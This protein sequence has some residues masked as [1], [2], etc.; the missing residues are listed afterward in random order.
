MHPTVLI[1]LSL[2][3]ASCG[4]A[5]DPAE[6]VISRLVYGNGDA[7][8]MLSD[9]SVAQERCAGGA[10]VA[11]YYCALLDLADAE[12]ELREIEAAYA[13]EH[14]AYRI[15]PVSAARSQE[16]RLAVF[17]AG[18]ERWRQLRDANCAL[19]TFDAG[20]SVANGVMV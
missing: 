2:L 10:Q 17:Q 3:L 7:M 13:Q 20:S 6:A 1:V 16:D 19:T 9:L 11:I 14:E 18:Q 4:R 8:S 5:Q 15:E 12:R